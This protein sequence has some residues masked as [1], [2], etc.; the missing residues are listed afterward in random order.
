MSCL[1]RVPFPRV[2]KDPK[3]AFFT[4]GLPS[5]GA[6]EGAV[7]RKMLRRPWFVPDSV[8]QP[9]AMTCAHPPAVAP[10]EVHHLSL[11]WWSEVF[12]A[13]YMPPLQNAFWRADFNHFPKE[14]SFIVHCTLSIV[15]CSSNPNLSCCRI[16]GIQPIRAQSYLHET[17]HVIAS[18]AMTCVVDSTYPPCFYASKSS[19][20]RYPSPSTRYTRSVSWSRQS[21]RGSG[22]V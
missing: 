22:A 1:R 3:D 13:A 12:R 10:P 2:K 7:T 6:G 5:V 20:I 9:A 11:R 15:N 8:H 18:F 16:G 21:R 4:S 14:N 19:T 17:T